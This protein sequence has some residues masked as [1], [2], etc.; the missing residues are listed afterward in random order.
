[1]LL[2]SAH[3]HFTHLAV[4]LILHLHLD[5]IKRLIYYLKL[6]TVAAALKSA[7]SADPF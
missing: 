4:A 1:M 6:L 3:L 7:C 2:R 5:S